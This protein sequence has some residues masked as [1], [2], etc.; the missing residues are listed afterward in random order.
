L[1]VGTSKTNV[2]ALGYFRGNSDPGS[3]VPDACRPSAIAYWLSAIG[4][5]GQPSQPFVPGALR[6]IREFRGSCP[7]CRLA[8][9]AVDPGLWTVDL[10][11]IRRTVRKNRKRRLTRLWDLGHAQVVRSAEILMS[12]TLKPTKASRKNNMNNYGA[13]VLAAGKA[14]AR[15]ISEAICNERAT[16]PAAKRTS[17]NVHVIFS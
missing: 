1:Y 12:V 9:S 2:E 15:R 14:R 13:G 8:L 3:Q 16:P 17:Q 4:Y 7:L 5:C 6:S 10:V 11:S